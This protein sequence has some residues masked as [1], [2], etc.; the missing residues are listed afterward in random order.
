MK[1]WAL[2]V[3]GVDTTPAR[4]TIVSS[5]K[6]PSG[7][8]I[9]RLLNT[10][11]GVYGAN[12]VVT[13]LNEHRVVAST[14]HSAVDPGPLY[15]SGGMVQLSPLVLS[16]RLIS[17]VVLLTCH[18]VTVTLSPAFTATVVMSVSAAEVFPTRPAGRSPSSSEGSLNSSTP[19]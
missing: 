13:H 10:T 6:A 11:A 1:P 12:S 4:C 18:N 9:P 16:L 14:I 3:V 15:C 2:S 5:R 17:H 19:A 7:P 8:V